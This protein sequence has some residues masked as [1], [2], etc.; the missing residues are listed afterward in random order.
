[1]VSDKIKPIRIGLL[2]QGIGQI[3]ADRQH[4]VAHAIQFC[5]PLGPQRIITKDNRH[6]RGPMIRRKRIIQTVNN[7]K[8]TANSLCGSGVFT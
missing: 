8:V 5:L 3:T 7:R 6:N 4:D 1:M 2:A